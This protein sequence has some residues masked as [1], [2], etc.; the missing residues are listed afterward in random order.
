M[1]E[2]RGMEGAAV[3]LSS[4]R[5]LEVLHSVEPIALTNIVQRAVRWMTERLVL[6]AAAQ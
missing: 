4:E 1:S 5:R 3:I 2:Q 6:V